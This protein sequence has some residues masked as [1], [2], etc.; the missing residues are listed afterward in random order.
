MAE[1][2]INTRTVTVYG[3]FAD[4]AV[5]SDLVPY[6]SGFNKSNC[7]AL[8]LEVKNNNDWRIGEGTLPTAGRCFVQLQDNGITGFTN[9]ETYFGGQFRVTLLK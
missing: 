8:S 9:L 6:P 2:Y 1:G 3:T 5:F 7:V 4:T